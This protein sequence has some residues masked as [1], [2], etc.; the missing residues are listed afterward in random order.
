[1]YFICFVSVLM[2]VQY[3][4]LFDC[5]CLFVVGCLVRSVVGCTGCAIRLCYQ[6]VLSG[7][8]IRLCYGYVKR[9]WLRTSSITLVTIRV[10]ICIVY[11]RATMR[12]HEHAPQRPRAHCL[13]YNYVDSDVLHHFQ[14]TF[15][16][17]TRRS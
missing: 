3:V 2:V 1:M 6:V 9:Y 12:T 4:A 13:K 11:N 10:D 15:M 17:L 16:D 5:R 8:A 14:H 7:C